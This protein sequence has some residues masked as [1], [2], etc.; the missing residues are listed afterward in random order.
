MSSTGEGGEGD[1]GI[2]PGAADTRELGTPRGTGE[3]PLN[4]LDAAPGLSAPE[5]NRHGRARAMT[6]FS[7][8]NATEPTCWGATTLGTGVRGQPHVCV[9]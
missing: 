2:Q 9:D 3:V 7:P 5:P 8:V 1:P 4:V 6:V